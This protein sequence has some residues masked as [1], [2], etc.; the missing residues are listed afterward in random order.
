MIMANLK[1]KARGGLGPSELKD[2]VRLIRANAYSH[3]PFPETW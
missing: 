3:G 1:K 2:V